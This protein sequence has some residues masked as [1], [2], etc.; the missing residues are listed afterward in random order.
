MVVD[1]LNELFHVVEDR[2]LTRDGWKHNAIV[3]FQ[4]RGYGDTHVVYCAAYPYSPHQIID[5]TGAGDIFVGSV[6][7]TFLL[8]CREESILQI[9]TFTAGY[10]CTMSG[11]VQNGIPSRE[12]LMELLL[13]FP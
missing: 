4:I 12:K 5:T 10:K 6:C 11:G 8:G 9:A 2:N 1:S 3:Y 7:S 13:D